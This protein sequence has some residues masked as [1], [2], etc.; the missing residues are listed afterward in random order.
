L[1]PHAIQVGTNVSGRPPPAVAGALRVECAVLVSWVG[2]LVMQMLGPLVARANG[3]MLAT[4]N[5]GPR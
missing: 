3:L 2:S 4:G 5:P 1:G